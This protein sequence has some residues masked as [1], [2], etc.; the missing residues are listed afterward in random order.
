M[1]E[2]TVYLYL[3]FEDMRNAKLVCV[4]FID[5][6][7]LTR[8]AINESA[9][10]FPMY[11]L[12][13]LFS[14][15]PNYQSISLVGGPFISVSFVESVLKM[16]TQRDLKLDVSF[17]V[18]LRRLPVLEGYE[19]KVTRDSELMLAD[20]NRNSITVN[21]TGVYNVLKT[22]MS[23]YPLLSPVSVVSMFLSAY[24]YT[25]RLYTRFMSL[26][27]PNDINN[28]PCLCNSTVD[29]VYNTYAKPLHET[30]MKNEK[31]I[32]DRTSTLVTNGV[33]QGVKPLF[34][35]LNKEEVPRYGTVWKIKKIGSVKYILS[36]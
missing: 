4:S 12:T 10:E 34:F 1:N 8:F 26:I 35:V 33:D 24:W 25:E 17:C 22:R 15:R 3:S 36:D 13:R 30:P 20:K 32:E 31:N 9:T 6:T 27:N 21:V 14:N 19:S 28:L 11:F 23:L 2:E 18:E 16:Y 5:R 29:N 7:K